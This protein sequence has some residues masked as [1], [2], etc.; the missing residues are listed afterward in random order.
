MSWTPNKI[1]ILLPRKKGMDTRKA[2]SPAHCLDKDKEELLEKSS[3]GLGAT[4]RVTVAICRTEP[5]Q[6]GLRGLA[7]E[8][9]MWAL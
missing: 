6:P 8:T 7:Q 3:L 4:P 9:R 5:P 1:R 2:N